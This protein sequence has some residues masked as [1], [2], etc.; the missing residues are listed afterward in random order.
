MERPNYLKQIRK[1]I[2]IAEPGSVFIPSD[3]FDIAEAAKV[4]VSLNRLKES[5]NLNSVIRGVFA[6]PRHSELLNKN[7]PPRSDDIAKA[8]ARKYGWT[9]IPC[10]DTA[11][12]MLGLSTQVSAVW[13][14]IS[15]GPYKTYNADGVKLKFKHTDNKNEI[16][17][18]SNKT[19]LI[20]QALKALR[21]NDITDAEIK[22]LSVQLTQSEKAKMMS[23]SQRTTAWVYDYIKKICAEDKV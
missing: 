8:I 7:I 12:N 1:R 17:E 14:Y 23:E 22:K 15:D 13:V 9:I 6:K 11:L 5:G 3:F 21:K 2:E 16:I 18:V 4:N 19:A 10:G 20:V